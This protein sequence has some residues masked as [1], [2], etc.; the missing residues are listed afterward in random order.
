M[1]QARHF[2]LT[3]SGVP[4]TPYADESGERMAE[5][6][7]A[8][9]VVG[10]VVPG[11]APAGGDVARGALA[12]R[13]GRDRFLLDL[14]RCPPHA[15]R[16]GVTSR[17]RPAVGRRR[18][19]FG[20]GG[21]LAA[22]RPFHPTPWPLSTKGFTRSRDR[23]AT[24]PGRFSDPGWRQDAG[25][26]APANT[27]ARVDRRRAQE[28]RREFPVTIPI[29]G[30]KCPSSR[31]RRARRAGRTNLVPWALA[32]TLLVDCPRAAAQ[33]SPSAEVD[34]RAPVPSD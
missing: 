10:G 32:A 15:A 31:A 4:V 12:L 8:E 33:A 3:P 1:R 9:Q 20:S 7:V 29:R 6:P 14:R 28:S 24:A 27:C 34:G 22:S 13:G 16:A 21:G 11:R 18:G 2:A 17:P 30:T 26:P 5:A 25:Q 19:A 23:L